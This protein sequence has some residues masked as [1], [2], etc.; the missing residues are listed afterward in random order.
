MQPTAAIRSQPENSGPEQES[1]VIPTEGRNLLSS[2]FA[3][4]R[5]KQ[6][7]PLPKA[8]SERRKLRK[9]KKEGPL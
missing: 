3:R 2:S 7:S 4:R 9:M 8:D 6:F 1:P 5:L